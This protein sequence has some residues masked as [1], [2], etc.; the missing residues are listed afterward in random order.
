MYNRENEQS[1]LNSHTLLFGIEN[2]TNTLGEN[3]ALPSS[4]EFTPT[5]Q[6][7]YSTPK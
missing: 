5:L 3:L 7:R 4:V 2:G 6:P 1:Q